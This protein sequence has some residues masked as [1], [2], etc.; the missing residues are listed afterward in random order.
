MSKN[1]KYTDEQLFNLAKDWFVKNSKIPSSLSF[2]SGM[3]T[4]IFNRFN[5][6][7]NYLILAELLPTG[8][9]TPPLE[10]ICPTCHENFP[11]KKYNKTTFCSVKCSNIS[12]KKHQPKVKRTRDEY[13][14]VIHAQLKDIPFESFG[15]EGRRKRVIE[16]QE[17]KCNKCKNN[18]W[19]G[20]PLPLEVD[21]INGDRE[22]NCRENLEALCPNCHSLTPTWKGRNKRTKKYLTDEE[23]TLILKQ[24]PNIC[25]GLTLAGMS[26]RGANYKRA[27]KLLKI[28]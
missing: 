12:R 18:T 11:A 5:S 8:K 4:V 19:M 1:Y 21:H 23:L 25:Q 26:P 14:L 15:W 20:R 28:V 6:W 17:S 27:K 24:A 10:K 3:R 2:G 22:D 9:V 13:L 16:Q 7:T